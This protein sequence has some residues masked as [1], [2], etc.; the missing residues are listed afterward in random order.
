MEFLRHRSLRILAALFA[1]LVIAGDLV[2]DAIHDGSGACA[3]ESQDSNHSSCPV[4]GCTI[5]T[6]SATAV[7]AVAI[8]MPA[9]EATVLVS[10]AD[11]RPVAGAEPAIDHPPQLA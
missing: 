5:H 7:D 10:A 8:V 2:A 9:V 6:G 1:F 4:C 3:T 11:D